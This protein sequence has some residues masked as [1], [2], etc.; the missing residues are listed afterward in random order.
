MAD[1]LSAYVGP[2]LLLAGVVFQFIIRQFK[3]VGEA[4]YWSVAV[5]LTIGVWLITSTTL[6]RGNHWQ[7]DS[8]NALLWVAA[9]VATVRGGSSATDAIASNAVAKHPELAGN[10]LVPKTNSL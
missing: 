10:L 8:I 7:L 4:V 1:D 5:A 9:G 2:L 6:I 3:N